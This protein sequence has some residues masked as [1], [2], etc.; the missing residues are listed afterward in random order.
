MADTKN[1]Y[2][3]DFGKDGAANNA[4]AEETDSKF[5]KFMDAQ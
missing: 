2:E 4:R 1:D 5:K 3:P